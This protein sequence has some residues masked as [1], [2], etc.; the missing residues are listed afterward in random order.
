MKL[1]FIY[2]CSTMRTGSTFLQELLT[3]APY[4]IILS[5]PR[6]NGINFVPNRENIQ[7][8]TAA[9]LK[10]PN[11]SNI[12]L[13][14]EQLNLE[15]VGVKEIRNRGWKG[16]LKAFV[17]NIKILI[18]VRNPK[19]IYLS[20]YGV[21]QR[22]NSWRPKF[23]FSP[24]GLYKEIQPELEVQKKLL[25]FGHT[26]VV[27]YEDL[28]ENFD[29][30]YKEIKNFVNSPIPDVGE[31]G[32]FHKTIPAGQHEVKMHQGKATTKA[33]ARWQ[34]EQNEDLLKQ[35]NRFFELMAE[36]CELWGYK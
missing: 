22:S 14:F 25:S 15:Q 6:F 31:V 27:K 19:D 9:G 11:T 23:G 26:L 18:P 36:Y 32:E 30:K 35:A 5:E 24:A 12:N 13:F 29:I 21:T 10:I 7:Q 33:V 20:A 17:K 34:R 1:P 4:S 3:K 28:C 8:I 2:I 16:Y